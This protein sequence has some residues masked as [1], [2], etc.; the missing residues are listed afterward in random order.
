MRRHARSDRKRAVGAARPLAT[1]P[2]RLTRSRDDALSAALRCEPRRDRR[3][4]RGHR[5]GAARARPACSSRTASCSARTTSCAAR[6]ASICRPKRLARHLVAPLDVR[7][8]YAHCVLARFCRLVERAFDRSAGA[9]QRRRER[10]GA[11]P[12][13]GI[14]RRRHHAVRRRPPERRGRLHPARAASVV[15]SRKSY[16]GAMFDVEEALRRWESVELR[17]W[18]EG[19]PNAADGADA[20]SQDRRLP[21]Q[22]RRSGAQGCAAHGSDAAR[23]A[24]ARARAARAVR[25]GG[26]ATSTA[27]TPQRRPCSSASTPTPTRSACTCPTPPARCRADALRRQPPSSTK[28]TAALPR[29]DAKERIRDAVAACAGVAADDAATE[30]MR[31]FCGYLLKNNIGQVDAVRA[32]HGGAYADRGHTERLI[33]VGDPLDDVQLRNL[34]FQAQMDTVEEGAGRSRHRRAH[35]ARPARAARACRCRCWCTSRYDARIP[36]ARR[37]RRARALRLRDAILERY[38]RSRRARH[39]ARPGG[40]ARRRRRAPCGVGTPSA[41][42]AE[43]VA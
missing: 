2:R 42:A 22:Q 24:A 12:P 14:S 3:G 19:V 4:V 16:A 18:R 25:G 37:A 32:W 1:A 38:A 41:A 43:V 9:H 7:A 15:A 10:R 20:L 40:R 17:R 21:F 36:G 34:A 5:A 26:R 6:S 31:W 35:P 39:A 23:A 30:G 13:L 8:L 28:R 11:D 27:A 33:V 29:D